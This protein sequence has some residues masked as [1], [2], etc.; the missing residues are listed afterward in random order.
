MDILD[1]N[2]YRP[3]ALTSALRRIIERILNGQ[4]VD[5]LIRKELILQECHG[6]IRGRGCVIALLEIIL[7]LME[8]I[9]CGAVST[10]LGVDIS[11]AFD[12]INRQKLLRQM[13]RMNC[14]EKALELL[15]SYFT[16]R[17]QQIEIGGK[18]S[19][20]RGSHIWVLQ[21]SGLSPTLFLIYFFRGCY[22]IRRC[23]GCKLEASVPPTLR[24]ARCDACG[25][26]ISYADDLNTD[27]RSTG[28][29]QKGY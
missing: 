7:E 6:F 15:A 2:G 8:G 12:C 14:G 28:G 18:K 19:A 23:P 5:F 13:K 16:L 22:A 10:L 21:G 26:A 17:T 9:E 20:K 27:H 3:L 4:L 29:G 24:N 11:S 25:A 1:P